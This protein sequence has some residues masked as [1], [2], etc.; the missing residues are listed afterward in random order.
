MIILTVVMAFASAMLPNVVS[1][2][3]IAPVTLLICDRWRSTPSRC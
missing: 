1:V 2:L 3:L